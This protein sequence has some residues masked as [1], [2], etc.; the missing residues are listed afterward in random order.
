MYILCDD[1]LVG[2]LHYRGAYDGG[3]YDTAQ[4][5]IR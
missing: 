2:G 5:V 3:W 1:P 4:D